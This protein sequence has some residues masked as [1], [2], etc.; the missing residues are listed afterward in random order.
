[1][2][3]APP[4]RKNASLRLKPVLRSVTATL[5]SSGTLPSAFTTVPEIEPGVAMV[6]V[7]LAPVATCS[8]KASPPPLR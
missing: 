6:M 4:T 1:M 5:S 3:K 2:V 8:A 7:T